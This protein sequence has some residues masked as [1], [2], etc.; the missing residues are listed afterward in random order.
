M[1]Y[2][3]DNWHC[4]NGVRLRVER[5]LPGTPDLARYWWP[6]HRAS[7][8]ASAARLPWAIYLDEWQMV[9]SARRGR[10][11]LL[12]IYVHEISRG[13]LFVD[14]DGQTYRLRPLS[15][16][17]WQ[18]RFTRCHVRTALLDARVHE[19]VPPP[20]APGVPGHRQAE[21]LGPRLPNDPRWADLAD[22]AGSTPRV[23]V[24][25]NDPAPH[26]WSRSTDRLVPRHEPR[27]CE[28]AELQRPTSLD[29]VWRA[30]DPTR[31]P[32]SLN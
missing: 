22:G 13:E 7:R 28:H 32:P 26:R 6:L 9:G 4:S 24:P 16:R 3:I 14:T 11:G 19:A 10:A 8:S 23:A 12:W 30:V 15:S 27:E 21:N 18:G 1:A 2:V 31:R 5:P 29:Q 25:H 17:P 20:L